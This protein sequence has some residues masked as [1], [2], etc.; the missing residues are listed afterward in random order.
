[1][2]ILKE[3]YHG[4][5]A[6][7]WLEGFGVFFGVLYIF[8]AAK[9]S[10]WC[11]PASLVGVSIYIIICYQVQL[12]AE[13]GLQFYYLGTTIYGWWH[14]RNPGK[15][16]DLPVSKMKPIQHSLFIVAGLILTVA[17]GYILVNQTNAQLPYLDSFTTIFSIFTTILVTRKVLENWLYWIVIDA[18]GAYI[19]F[20]RELY[21]TSLLFTAYVIIAIFGYVKWR[22]SYQKQKG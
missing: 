17:L 21:L 5:L 14:W 20:Q 1:M 3:L 10:I 18:V 11:W 19:F 9:E 12:Y 6:M 22:R 2:D 16:G 8:F 4:L 13:M 7:S 15:K